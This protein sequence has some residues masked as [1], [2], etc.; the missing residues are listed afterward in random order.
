ME[1]QKIT[2]LDIARVSEEIKTIIGTAIVAVASDGSRSDLYMKIKI[3]EI[4]IKFHIGKKIS[5]IGRT[6]TMPPGLTS[7]FK[8][9][10]D[11]TLGGCEQMGRDRI[12]R[13]TLI[14]KD[15]LGREKSLHIIL[16]VIPNRG[17]AYL[18]DEKD[19]IKE[20]LKKRT[21]G[22]YAPPK[23]L[24]KPSVLNFDDDLIN[25]ILESGANI[26]DEI[27]GLS[28]RD[29]LNIESDS[30]SGTDDLCRILRQYVKKAIKPGPAWIV[31]QDGQQTGFS[32][33]EPVLNDGE[34]SRRFDSALE[35]Y[36]SYFGA[37]TTLEREVD[38][39]E[40]PLPVLESAITKE[41]KKLAAIE[42]DLSASNKAPLY[43]TYG[44]LILANIGSIERGQKTARLE[45][46]IS[47]QP[48]YFKIEL[49]PAKSASANAEIYFKK[50]KK[51]ESSKKALKRRHDQVSK[52]IARFENL[53]SDLA[54]DPEALAAEMQKLIPRKGAR[55]IRQ[56]ITPRKPYRR[57]KASCGWDILV[58]RSKADN[59]EL[60]LKIAAKDDYWFHAWQA[61]G[62]H[63]VLRLPEK[64]AVPDKQTLLEAASLAAW[65]SKARGSTKVPVLY[66]QARYVRKPRKSAP[67]K[68]TVEREKQ[69]MVKPADPK[70][71]ATGDE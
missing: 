48:Q 57:F 61:A 36:D 23:P 21:V 1:I 50:Y 5:Y 25:S 39:S 63:V 7:V 66:T 13:L 62:S 6:N 31:E 58:G 59:D 14:G 51:A 44:G 16:E 30:A 41:K 49:D 43:K 47:S 8:P 33:V 17:D 54:D 56:P 67:G 38:K 68:V 45:N 15:R 70:E 22:K 2:V 27:Y 69:L 29:I 9:A 71:F 42:R 46:P 20:V 60:S 35:M 64:K 40:S 18:I 3:P 24:R 55:K 4:V 53:K 37:M 12:V 34:T 65:F 32:L 19:S 52:L 26:Y 28:E 11:L 10:N